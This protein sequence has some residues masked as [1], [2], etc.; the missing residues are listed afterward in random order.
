M[1]TLLSDR[2]SQR[3][4]LHI[5]SSKKHRVAQCE[6][7]RVRIYSVQRGP[8]ASITLLGIKARWLSL[9]RC[10]FEHCTVSI[11]QHRLCSLC[12]SLRHRDQS[13]TYGPSLLSSTSVERNAH[14]ITNLA[15]QAISMWHITE[16]RS[17]ATSSLEKLYYECHATFLAF[18]YWNL[19]R[20]NI[21]NL[22]VFTVSKQPLRRPSLA[23]GV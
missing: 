5:F 16:A 8:R 3:W 7:S 23:N 2:L 10:I 4:K 18:R 21:V 6:S 13:I 17:G 20:L 19:S 11:C 22:A 9:L 1:P 12:A 15:Y 14:W